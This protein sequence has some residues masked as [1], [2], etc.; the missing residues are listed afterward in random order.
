[1]TTNFWVILYHVQGVHHT[2]Q[3]DPGREKH[4]DGSFMFG[5]KCT[6]WS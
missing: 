4:A 2:V 5:L 3:D 6:S 1:M